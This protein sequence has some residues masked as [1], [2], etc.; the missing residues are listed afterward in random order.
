MDLGLTGKVALVTGGSR[1]IGQAIAVAFAQEGAQVSICG[2]TPDDLSRAAD[3][4]KAK[5]VELLTIEA[6]LTRAGDA[7]KVFQATLD[8][9]GQLDI[10][11]NNVGGAQGD[12]TW[13]AS[14]ADWDAVLQLNFLSAVRLTRL[15]IPQMQRQGGGRIIHIASIYGREWGG[16][17]TYNASKAAMISFSKMLAR[18]LAPDHILVNTVAPGS[19]LFP[20]GAW[21]RRQQQSPEQIARFLETDFPSGRFGRPEEVAPIVV[22]LASAQASLITGAC[23]NVDGGQSRSLF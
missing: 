11:V 1:G 8:R 15:V 20:G 18:Q 16:P 5:G 3:A 4:L 14:D 21:E 7:Q 10:L 9:F 22:F 19:I 12:P 13:G 23:I 17:T 2:R 6:D